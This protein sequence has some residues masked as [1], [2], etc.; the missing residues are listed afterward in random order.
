MQH[1]LTK[2]LAILV[3]S[4]DLNPVD[5][6]LIYSLHKSRVDSRSTAPEE[7]LQVNKVF[8]N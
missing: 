8:K 2:L 5:K 7:S 1:S 3:K 4:L 6:F